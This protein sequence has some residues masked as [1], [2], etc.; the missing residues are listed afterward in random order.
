MTDDNTTPL[1]KSVQA[2]AASP[3]EKT[4]AKVSQLRYSTNNNNNNH[5]T[6]SFPGQP[7]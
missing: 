5:L 1:M 4:P 7:G 2:V 3:A 6:A